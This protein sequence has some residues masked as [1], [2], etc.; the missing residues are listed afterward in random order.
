[1]KY[2]RLKS[3][4][5]SFEASTLREKR[6]ASGITLKALSEQT[7]F[8]VQYLSDVEKCRRIVSQDKA[9]TI[10]YAMGVLLK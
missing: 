9:M 4:R 5:K 2:F 8:T 10:D 6:K 7:G 1:M 3:V